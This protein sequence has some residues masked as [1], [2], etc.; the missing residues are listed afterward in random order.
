M[1]NSAAR[2]SEGALPPRRAALTAADAPESR[3][4]PAAP[5]TCRPQSAQRSAPPAHDALPP[6]SRRPR[7]GAPRA[8]VRRC[9][10][11]RSKE[12]EG[13]AA[14]PR[15][16]TAP[17]RQTL[18]Q[19]R[20]GPPRRT[21]RTYKSCPG[22]SAAPAPRRRRPG[23]PSR[24]RRRLRT[25]CRG[26][27]EEEGAAPP[28]ALRPPR[29]AP[30]SAVLGGRHRA[31]RGGGARAHSVRFP[32]ALSGVMPSRPAPPRTARV[33]TGPAPCVRLAMGARLTGPLRLPATALLIFV[34]C[35]T[36]IGDRSCGREAR[37]TPVLVTLI[38]RSAAVPEC[39]C[40]TPLQRGCLMGSAGPLLVR[41]RVAA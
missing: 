13:A 10:P 12:G 40:S 38:P 7:P 36:F 18:T 23:P 30:P 39:C 28:P 15:P 31:A 21:A 26:R 14:A 4:A 17:A 25:A 22:G 5:G 3:G 20:R 27:S 34:L 29:S 35:V 6:P 37:W 2:G 32:A 33:R 9:R 11:P 1:T 19:S 41:L 16:G 24:Q 8:A